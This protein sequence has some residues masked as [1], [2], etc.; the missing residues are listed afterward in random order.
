MV[1]SLIAPTPQAIASVPPAQ[2]LL[3][4]ETVQFECVKQHFAD[5]GFELPVDGKHGRATGLSE[6]ERFWLVSDLPYRS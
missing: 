3:P 5:T 1:A 4:E 2:S 6:G